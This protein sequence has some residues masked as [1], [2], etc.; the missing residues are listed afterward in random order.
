MNPWLSTIVKRYWLDAAIVAFAMLAASEVLAR[1]DAEAAPDLAAWLAAALA[2]SIV[3]PLLLRRKWNL[4]GP[5]LLWVLAAGVSFLDGRLV[6]FSTGDFAAG[7]TASCLLGFASNSR[8]ARLGLVVVLSA[9][10]IIMSNAPD[11]SLSDY[12][13]VPGLFAVLWLAG[14]AVQQRTARLEAAESRIAMV[15]QEREQA[16][17]DAITS[18]RTRMAR[19]LH[20]VLGHSLS[21]MTIQAAAVRTVLTAEQINERDTLLSVE[22]TGREAM[23]EMRRLVGILRGPNAP[24]QLEP[25]PGLGQLN[26][27]FEQSKQSGLPVELTVEGDPAPLPPGPDLELTHSPVMHCC[28]S[29]HCA[30]TAAPVPQASTV[31]P[32]WHRPEASQQPEG[33]FEGE[34]SSVHPNHEA[35]MATTRAKR[36]IICAFSFKLGV[37][38][39]NPQCAAHVHKNQRQSLRHGKSRTTRSPCD[40][41]P[42]NQGAPVSPRRHR[43]LTS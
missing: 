35:L 30:Q 3:F 23:S 6:V 38:V 31:W 32:A 42:V 37:R 5:T 10:M 4:A 16:T 1:Q 8:E 21:V 33:Q 25:Q 7:M 22:Q 17:R 12:F 15:D 27:L 20:D 9:S 24:L 14:F 43:R 40:H 36:A 11:A 2:A 18:E 34:H 41:R 26:R 39:Q 29:A 28:P 19:E 13:L